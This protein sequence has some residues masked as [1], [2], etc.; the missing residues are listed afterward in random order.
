MWAFL[1]VGALK[2]FGLILLAPV[3][4]CFFGFM[5][6]FLAGY[7]PRLTRKLADDPT[8]DPVAVALHAA[9]KLDKA[10]RLVFLV[11]LK[12]AGIARM[13]AVF[14]SLSQKVKFH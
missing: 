7:I 8:G 2:L 4:I 5:V 14:T 13:P 3:I 10:Q 1:V 6:G 9:S 11:K 12:Q